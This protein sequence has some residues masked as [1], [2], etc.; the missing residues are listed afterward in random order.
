MGL[1]VCKTSGV[2]K[3]PMRRLCDCIQTSGFWLTSPILSLKSQRGWWRRFFS[4]CPVPPLPPPSLLQTCPFKHLLSDIGGCTYATIVA[5]A[6]CASP[7]D[8]LTLGEIYN[9]I[10]IHR[11]LIPNATRPNW[12]S[13][14][15]FSSSYGG[16]Q[17]G[18]Q[19]ET[20]GFHQK[21]VQLR[22]WR[23]LGPL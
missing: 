23:R 1:R 20:P 22:A 14:I 11:R 13:Y 21:H 16:G 4:L 17:V 10:E 5:L 8:S 3:V 18:P 2:C 15:R 7:K 9:F 12:V 19:N 6:L